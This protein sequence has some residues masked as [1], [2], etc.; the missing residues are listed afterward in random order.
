MM[1]DLNPEE[2]L[3]RALNHLQAAIQ[4]LDRVGAPGQIA[5]N[6]DLGACQLMDLIGTRAE[7][8]DIGQ[9]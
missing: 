4:I 1:D 8:A 2:L 6:V 5:A 7:F 9:D 3:N